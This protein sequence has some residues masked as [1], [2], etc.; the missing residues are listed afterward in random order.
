MDTSLVI[1]LI[2][3]NL[4][5]GLFFFLLP[6]FKTPKYFFAVHVTEKFLK[7]E[8]K[9]KFLNRYRAT[10]FIGYFLFTIFFLFFY[11]EKYHLFLITLYCTYL[12]FCLIVFVIF[13]EL[14]KLKIGRNGIEITPPA[15]FT[16]FDFWNPWVEFYCWLLTA[17]SF[18]IG[19]Y[20][21]PNIPDYTSPLF[22]HQEDFI[23]VSQKTFTK[24]LLLP[25]INTVIYLSATLLQMWILRI[26]ISPQ[27]YFQ[28]EYITLKSE[29]ANTNLKF[30]NFIKVF[31]MFIIAIISFQMFNAYKSGPQFKLTTIMLYVIMSNIV[32]LFAVVP[33]IQKWREI[34]ENFNKLAKNIENNK[35]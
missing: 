29:W 28:T 12:L 31:V 14:V 25:I 5:A 7:S 27:I 2:S 3:L 18:L 21:Y 11:K 33:Y 8:N 32:L 15:T 23:L 22:S 6:I 35:T 30:I 9:G 24:V 13:Y 34:K 1:I 4:F 17:I 26:R 20:Y 16:Y 19:M 10:L